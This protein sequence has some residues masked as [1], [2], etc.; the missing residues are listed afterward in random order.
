MF[1][2][3]WG[4]RTHAVM[5][6]DYELD[7]PDP[8]NIAGLCDLAAF[9]MEHPMP[10]ERALVALRRPGT[11]RAEDDV[12][13]AQPFARCVVSGVKRADGPRRRHGAHQT[14]KG[15]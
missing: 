2:C 9:C 15:T 8:D 3:P 4:I 13:A 7:L 14:G 10:G 5:P 6:V 12:S 1:L 11:T